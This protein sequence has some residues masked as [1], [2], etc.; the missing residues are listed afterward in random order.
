MFS[1]WKERNAKT[2]KDLK[3][4]KENLCQS[5]EGALAWDTQLCGAVAVD[6]ER[7]EAAARNSARE[8]GVQKYE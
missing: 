3:C 7:L 8:K 6:E 1:R 4:E 5:E 2:R